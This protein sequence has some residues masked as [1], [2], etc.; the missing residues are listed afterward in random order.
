M[1]IKSVALSYAHS[2]MGLGY[3][4]KHSI[5]WVVSNEKLPSNMCKMR[6][7]RSS[8][9]CAKYHPGL[10]SPFIHSVVANDFASA[11]SDLGHRC[12]HMTRRHFF[13]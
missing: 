8:Y 9:A 6:R 7:F 13:V 3:I 10:C 4:S 11:Q 1:A 2:D 5:S 12:P